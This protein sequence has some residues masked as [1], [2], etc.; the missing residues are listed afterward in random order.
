MLNIKQITLATLLS[1][2]AISVAQ[3]T[4]VFPVAVKNNSGIPDDQTYVLIKAETLDNKGAATGNNC[5]MHFKADGY[6]TC[7]LA[8]ANFN[9]FDAAVK[10]SSLP[11]NTKGQR[12]MFLPQAASGRIYFSYKYPMDLPI[13]GK[14]QKVVDADGF[15]PQ[16]SNYY[17]LYDKVEFTFN[18]LGTWMN[19]TAVDFFSL[20]IRITQ[21][22]SQVY[23]ATGLSQTRPVIL[24]TVEHILNQDNANTAF[25][26]NKLL[27]TNTSD[28]NVKTVLRLMS[29]GKA[30]IKDV[31]N[32]D[33]FD[34]NIFTDP[35][36][37]GINGQSYIDEIWNFYRNKTLKID[38]SELPG[39]AKPSYCTGQVAAGST[40]FVFTCDNGDTV[41]IPKQTSSLPFFAGAIG[42]FNAPNNTAKAIIVRELSSAT[43]VGLLPAPDG[44]VLNREYFSAHKHQY[45][46][47]NT[48]AGQHYDLYAKALHAFGE[49]NPIYTF[50]YD[51]ALAQDGTLH[52]PTPNGENPSAAV[53]TLGAVG[54][55]EA[56]LP[57]VFDTDSKTYPIRVIIPKDQALNPMLRV[58]LHKEDGSTEV[59]QSDHQ[60]SVTSPMRM[61]ITNLKDGVEYKKVNLYLN[62]ALVRPMVKG[63]E[64]ILVKK[65]AGAATLI[66]FPASFPSESARVASEN[67]GD[68]KD[69]LPTGE[70]TGQTTDQSA[71]DQTDQQPADQT[72]NTDNTSSG[73]QTTP[74]NGQQNNTTGDVTAPVASITYLGSDKAE[75]KYHYTDKGDF[76][77]VH[78]MVNGHDVGGYH[79]QK[80]SDGNYAYT[81]SGLKPGDVV[82]SNFTTI[83]NAA[84]EPMTYTHQGS[85]NNESTDNGSGQADTGTAQPA[86]D[87]T[88]N[89]SDQTTAAPVANIAGLGDGKAEVT[90]D[91]TGPGDFAVVHV[92]INGADAGGYRMEKTSDGH[93]TYVIDGLKPGDVVTTDF[94]TMQSASA[95]P[96]S[97]TYAAS[98]QSTQPADQTNT[99]N[100]SNNTSTDNNSQ[101]GSGM[102]TTPTTS[103][104][105][106]D[107]NSAT[108]R[109][110]H[111][112]PFAVA[113][114]NVN[115]AY[116]GG[117][118]MTK[119][120]DGTYE[121]T[122][123]GLKPGDQVTVDFTNYQV[124]HDAQTQYTQ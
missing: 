18:H 84:A 114:I 113:H 62:K 107:A 112:G 80:T 22:G 109:Y 115:G 67:Q 91:Y 5:F 82:K 86:Q 81:I 117:Y 90:Y 44:T 93:Y 47:N 85:S 102:A 97:Y 64:G 19:P 17:T 69:V 96:M 60:Y 55:D 75:V 99:G 92:K 116:V 100:S 41:I 11:K 50:A 32:T 105:K 83:E 111:N 37:Y 98:G 27:L 1:L 79:M 103:I 73:S 53:I 95:E 23:H 122:M 78:L 57:H 94:T 120:A 70:H 20:P 46:L 68:V 30:M 40:N 110:E 26:W 119:N 121:Y 33:P 6:A 88:N 58:V 76:A 24:S 104:T 87:H 77:I 7:D 15:K 4:A 35:V 3:A 49:E 8:S 106:M 39:A 38:I 108:I 65:E 13:D 89:P 43:V 54:I 34:E 101:G 51:D 29:P 52:D 124:P 28:N 118:G 56:N 66:E 48:K 59:L 31:P 14:T 71:S 12:E 36:K 45:Y 16:D 74:G 72:N 61:D 123:N 63:A 25:Q 2:G 21:S 9:A 42:D 10:L